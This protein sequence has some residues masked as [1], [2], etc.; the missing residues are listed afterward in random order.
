[1]DCQTVSRFAAIQHSAKEIQTFNIFFY[2]IVILPYKYSTNLSIHKSANNLLT[3]T[4]SDY[5]FSKNTWRPA[6]F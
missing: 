1:V 3:V 5:Y 6:I 4:S 2:F